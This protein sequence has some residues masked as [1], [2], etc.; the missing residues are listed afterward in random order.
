MKV[1]V[2]ETHRWRPRESS[3]HKAKPVCARLYRWITP[4]LRRLNLFIRPEIIPFLLHASVELHFADGK[5]G[6]YPCVSSL[7]WE[8]PVLKGL[9][10]CWDIYSGSK[11]T[12]AKA[13]SSLHEG[14][15]ILREWEDLLSP[16]CSKKKPQLWSMTDEFDKKSLKTRCFCSQYCFVQCP[17]STVI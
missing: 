13:S 4:T 5:T 6:W 9:S 3:S 2:S 16:H 11:Q 1:W 10:Y 14:D 7:E 8:C 15:I 17:F 12:E